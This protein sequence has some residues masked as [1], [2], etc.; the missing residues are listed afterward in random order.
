[1]A[2]KLKLTGDNPK[3]DN[4]GKTGDVH[5]P[6]NPDLQPPVT[7]LPVQPPAND[8][9]G[10]KGNPGDERIRVPRDPMKPPPIKLPVEPPEKG[11]GDDGG[12]A[13]EQDE[14]AKSV[15]GGMLV[16]LDGPLSDAKQLCAKALGRLIVGMPQVT[17]NVRVLTQKD[18]RAHVQRTRKNKPAGTAGGFAMNWKQNNAMWRMFENKAKEALREGRV[19]VIE[20]D[21]IR[22]KGEDWAAGIA[23]DA[24]AKAVQ[25]HIGTSAEQVQEFEAT[26]GIRG[27]H[28]TGF[29]EGS[30]VLLAQEV[31]ERV[32][33]TSFEDII[34]APVVTTADVPKASRR[35]PV[36][37]G[38]MTP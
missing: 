22:M 20:A 5:I 3:A 21:V 9:D 26:R 28:L 33:P 8:G 13:P 38:G 34:S 7:T 32:F 4:A 6:R 35:Q 29:D 11:E 2:D 14:P 12:S 16:L 25:Y 27:Y 37:R 23:R 15:G 31:G 36:R 1:M 18:V 10:N 19:V 30:A 17:G 24:K